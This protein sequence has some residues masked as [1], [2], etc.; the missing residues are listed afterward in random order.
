MNKAIF[1]ANVGKDAEYTV[2][3][4]KG[5]AKFTVAVNH[6]AKND[7][8]EWENVPEWRIVTVFGKTAEFCRDY[9]KKGKTV[10][11]DGVPSPRYYKNKLEEIVPCIDVLANTVELI[12]KKDSNQQHTAQPTQSVPNGFVP[13]DPNEEMPF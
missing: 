9:V 12:D 6:R 1:H 5:M 7:K 2:K 3:D 4:G 13:V 8:G 10:L 11:I